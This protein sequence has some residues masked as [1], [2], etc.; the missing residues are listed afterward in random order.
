LLRWTC[1]EPAA[2]RN[3]PN[4]TPTGNARR[5]SHKGPESILHSLQHEKP[6]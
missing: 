4:T 3:S 1:S 5:N 6:L 2:R